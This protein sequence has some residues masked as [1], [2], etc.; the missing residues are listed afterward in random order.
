MNPQKNYW[1]SKN[2]MRWRGFHEKTMKI[3]VN[4]NKQWSRED[5]ELELFSVVLLNMNKSSE[6]YFVEEKLAAVVF[7]SKL[8]CFFDSFSSL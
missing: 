4:K 1:L 7:W 5:V 3:V 6:T 2:S 8:L